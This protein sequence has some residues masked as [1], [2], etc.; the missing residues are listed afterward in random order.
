M[1]ELKKFAKVIKQE[2]KEPDHTFEQTL[3]KTIE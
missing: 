2:E 1:D 3:M